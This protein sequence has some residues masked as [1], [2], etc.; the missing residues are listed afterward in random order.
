MTVC[1]QPAR[2]SLAT[3]ASLLRS[4]KQDQRYWA[5]G[6]T[7]HFHF[8]FTP[9]DGAYAWFSYYSNG[10]F[11]NTVNATAKSGTTVPQ[12]VSYVNKAGLVS[13][14]ISL[15][16]RRYLKG[17]FDKEE[18]WNLY[19]YAGFGLMLGRVDNTHSV[20][21]DTSLY[22]VPV[23]NGKGNFKRLTLD[24]GLGAE[25]PIGADTYLYAEGRVQVPTSDY[26]SQYLFVNENAPLTAAI[27]AG[28]RVLF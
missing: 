20:S 18:N 23:L 7:I 26:P 19:S 13:K 10:K 4:F 15:G 2:F 28:F 24:L 11:S 9:K 12:S 22:N 8:H 3:D 5:V 6:Q 25:F 21:I 14:H 1:G 17:S 27:N 16:W